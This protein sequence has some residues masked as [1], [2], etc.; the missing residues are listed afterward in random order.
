MKKSDFQSRS[1]RFR[2]KVDLHIALMPVIGLIAAFSAGANAQRPSIVPVAVVA[3]AI[4]FVAW[5]FFGT[6]YT[7]AGDLL[8]VQCGPF[9]RRIRTSSIR[10]V[11]RTRTMLSAPALSLDRLE[12]S[13][14]E[15]VVVVSPR[16]QQPFLEA[17]TSRAPGADCGDLYG[18]SRDPIRHANRDGIPADH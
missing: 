8:I 5:I 16:D 3:A 10:Q 7:F 6:H 15:G 4:G 9:R 2:S 11:R 17:L 1:I 18:H 13:G 12:L 14:T